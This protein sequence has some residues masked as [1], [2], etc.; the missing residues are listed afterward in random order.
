MSVYKDLEK[1]K[2]Y[3]REWA[4]VRVRVNQLKTIKFNE[5]DYDVYLNN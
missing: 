1:R 4:R 5:D 3:Q 2:E